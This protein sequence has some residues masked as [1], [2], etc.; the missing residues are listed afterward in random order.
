MQFM[1]FKKGVPLGVPSATEASSLSPSAAASIGSSPTAAAAAAGQGAKMVEKQL[2]R[3]PSSA[4]L[5]GN[6]DQ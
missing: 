6:Y 3:L 2:K 1:S 4:Q 5:L